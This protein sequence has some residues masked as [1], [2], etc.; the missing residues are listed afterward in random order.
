MHIGAV[1][2]PIILYWIPERKTL[3]SNFSDEGLMLEKSTL[4]TLYGGKFT[5]WPENET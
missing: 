2:I 1:N 4:E 3:S 5:F